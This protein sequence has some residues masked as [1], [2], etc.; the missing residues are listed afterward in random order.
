MSV[1]DGDKYTLGDPRSMFYNNVLEASGNGNTT[2][3]TSANT[4]KTNGYPNRWTGT[5]NIVAP[6]SSA[7]SLYESQ[8]PANEMNNWGTT[9]TNHKNSLCFYYPT[10]EIAKDAP[11]SKYGFIAPVLR[12]AS[13]FGK[14]SNS[15]SKEVARKRCATYQESGYPAGRWRLPTNAEI[16]Y[17]GSLSA[18]GK[19]PILFGTNDSNASRYWSSTGPVSVA[20][21]G[22]SVEDSNTTT[23]V[24]I[25]CVYDD[26]YWVKEDGTPDKCDIRTFTW[27]D[28][29]KV[30][31]QN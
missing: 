6:Y 26:W 14:F 24:G 30:N 27:G 20:N 25:R 16:K 12:I 3:D 18:S 13:S 22:G 15:I 5:T 2:L 11:G 7:P 10:E 9:T 21:S 19:I 28:K 23:T 17:I 1:E 29:P 4:T 8:K 31:P